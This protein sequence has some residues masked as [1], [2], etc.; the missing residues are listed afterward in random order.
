MAPHRVPGPL[1]RGEPL[2]GRTLLVH[3]EGGFGDTLQFV[4]FLP[5]L[6][7]QAAH[8]I[9]RVQAPLIRLLRRSLPQ[10]IRIIAQNDTLPPFDIQCSMLSL[11]RAL[12]TSLASI[13][14]DIPYLTPDPDQV[15]QWRGRLRAISGP[16]WL[17]VG[18]VWAGAP[19][20]GMGQ[21]RAMDQR[22]SL[23]P[24]RLAPLARIQG[25]RFI[26][27]QMP[28]E[29][30]PSQHI[31]DPASDAAGTCLPIFDPPIL[32]PTQHIA[33]FD[34]TAAL[35]ANLDLVIAVD[36]AVAH[37]AGALGRPVWV[38]SR[39]DSCWRWLTS[40]ADSPWYPTLRLYRQ[41]QPGAWA[42]V[43]ARIARDLRALRPQ[44]RHAA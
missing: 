8:I 42:P 13:P 28:S 37:L 31:T 17:R 11:P 1:W 39:Y 4:R 32:D 16:E 34:D 20:L 14:A 18:L 41:P 9:L 3:E 29:H 27:L 2:A 35:I 12:R 43:L 6:A 15:A 33:D 7:A 5:A 44:S 26:S 21:M 22:R 38:M 19:R 24:S 10:T 25:V 36:T 40:R 23:A 30:M